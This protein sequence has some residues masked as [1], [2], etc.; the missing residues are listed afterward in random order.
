MVSMVSSPII[1]P[2]SEGPGDSG[3]EF[4]SR[5]DSEGI[6]AV[7]SEA[8]QIS[9]VFKDGWFWNVHRGHWPA[10]LS[11]GVVPLELHLSG[12][13]EC[14]W[15]GLRFV[16]VAERF[17]MAEMAALTICTSGGLIPHA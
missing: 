14:R 16:E 4:A 12:P 10:G 9:H 8:P 11:C 15:F 3:L 2:L 5:W 13:V 1:D 17:D 7:C 6:V